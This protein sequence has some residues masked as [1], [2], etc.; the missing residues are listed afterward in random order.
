MTTPALFLL[1]TKQS[2]LYANDITLCRHPSSITEIKYFGA[3]LSKY[4]TP[5]TSGFYNKVYKLYPDSLWSPRSI[6][7]VQPTLHLPI[8]WCCSHVLTAEMSNKGDHMSK[9]A[10]NTHRLDLN[11]EKCASLS[12]LTFTCC[13]CHIKEVLSGSFI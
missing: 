5:F 13:Q 10:Q 12:F 1:L 11:R 2:L 7:G 3:H 8:V 9:K 6:I 4:F